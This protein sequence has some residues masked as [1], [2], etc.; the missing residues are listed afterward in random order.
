MKRGRLSGWQLTNRKLQRVEIVP[1]VPTKW[2]MF[3]FANRIDDPMIAL[4]NG[5]RVI[6]AG[7]VLKHKDSAF[8]PIDVLDFL[9]ITTRWD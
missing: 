6:I 4:R 5:Q 8:I 1:P 7:F 3:C 9:S 2:D